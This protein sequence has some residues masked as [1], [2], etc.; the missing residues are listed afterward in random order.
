VSSLREIMTMTNKYLTQSQRLR[1]L[2]PAAGLSFN[3]SIYYKKE[4]GKRRRERDKDKDKK[5]KE[6]G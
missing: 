4:E 3:R 5:Q 1:L 2:S 6:K